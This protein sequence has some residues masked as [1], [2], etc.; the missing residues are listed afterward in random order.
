VGDRFTW[1]V[2]NDVAGTIQEFFRKYYRVQL[3]SNA[4]GGETILDSLAT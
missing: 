1:T 2:A 4:A 3:P